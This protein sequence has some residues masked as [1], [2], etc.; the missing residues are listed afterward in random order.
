MH[1]QKIKFFFT[2]LIS[3][4]L[5]I[6]RQLKDSNQLFGHLIQGQGAESRYNLRT[7][8]DEQIGGS[9]VPKLLHLNQLN[10]LDDPN[11]SGE[12]ER[13]FDLTGRIAT[14]PMLSLAHR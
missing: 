5:I 4:F 3:R 7:L 14:M 1:N 9:R 8:N 12:N 11:Y 6:T 13:A 2:Y 10:K